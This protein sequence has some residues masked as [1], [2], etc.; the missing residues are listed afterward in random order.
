MKTTVRLLA[1]TSYA[2][3]AALMILLGTGALVAGTGL[4]PSLQTALLDEA[5]GN[6]AAVHILQELAA[7]LVFAGAIALWFVRHY[8][9]SATF[10]W[11]FT[12]F[13]GLLVPIHWFDVR[14][15]SATVGGVIVIAIPFL[16]FA[17]IG[18][19]RAATER[20][21]AGT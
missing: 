2:V 15:S 4:I 7:L 20:E 21:S 19:L 3:A 5:E 1:Q 10:H 14:G 12:L 6:L 17:V 8:D 16:V 18:Y 11:A 9:Q 13:L